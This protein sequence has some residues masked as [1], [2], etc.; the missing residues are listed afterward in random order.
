[1]STPMK[2][3]N[4]LTWVFLF[5]LYFLF[6]VLYTFNVRAIS[7]QRA[8]T[9]ANTSELIFFLGVFGTISYLDNLWNLVPI[10]L[11]IYL[12]SYVSVKG[13]WLKKWF[14]RK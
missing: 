3:V 11:G 2:E 1:M 14:D 9:A 13:W 10:G 5:L 7:N 4:V 8:F 6:D 12:G